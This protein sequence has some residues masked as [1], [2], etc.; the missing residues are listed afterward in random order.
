MI[1]VRYKSP[2]G[3]ALSEQL[4]REGLAKLKPFLTEPFYSRNDNSTSLPRLA[5]YHTRHPDTTFVYRDKS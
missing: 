5:F 2:L 4:H 1:L 3:Q